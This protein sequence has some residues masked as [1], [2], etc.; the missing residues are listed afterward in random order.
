M[1]IYYAWYDAAT[2]EILGIFAEG[3]HEPMLEPN[4]EITAAQRDAIRVAPFS[5]R[6]IDGDLVYSPPPSLVDEAA[7]GGLRTVDGE[8]ETTRL[9]FITAG[10]GQTL[11]YSE[12]M[13]ESQR[14]KGAGSPPLDPLAA[15]D[16]DAYPLIC[17]EMGV[18]GGAGSTAAQVV[19]E[20]DA[21][22]LE[23]RKL[24]A[25]IEKVRL[26]AKRDIEVARLAQDTA[27]IDAAVATALASFSAIKS[28]SPAPLTEQDK[29]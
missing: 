21:A 12:K 3:E 10:A 28:T 5:Y 18:T 26:T 19:A 13:A 15:A 25:Q 29:F 14:W 1:T 9:V 4:I 16:A 7:D 22:A 27:A 17:A 2:G 23:W 24:A 6:V 20:W 11:V 8:A